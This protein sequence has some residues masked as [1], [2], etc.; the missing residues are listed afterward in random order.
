MLKT[1]KHLLT[2]KTWYFL[3]FAILLLPF[4]A[5]R[6]SPEVSR[7]RKIA[8][9]LK[10]D[11]QGER[12]FANRIQSACRNLGWKADL[13]EI[14]KFRRLKKHSY[15][16]VINLV[17][18]PCNFRNTKYY[19]AIFHPLHHYFDPDGSLSKPYRNYDGYL[20]TYSPKVDDRNFGAGGMP[21]IK[22]YPT[23]QTREYK[24][25]DPTALFYLG[26]IWGN[27][28]DDAKMQQFL[29]LLDK[30]SFT[31]IYGNPLLK[32]HC[33]HNYHSS[34][35][36]DSDSVCE[37]ANQAGV[38]LVLHSN[39]H[40][41]Y[42]LPSGRIFEAAAA[43]TTIICDENPFVRE[44]FGDSVLYINTDGS[45]ES[46]HNQIK[47]H[48]D[49]IQ[50]DKKAAREKARSAHTIYKYS[51]SLEE[52]LLRL[53]AFHDERSKTAFL[54]WRTKMIS[55]FSSWVKKLF[56]LS[57]LAAI[58]PII[59]PAPLSVIPNIDSHYSLINSVDFH[60]Q[61]NIACAVYT[62]NNKIVLYEIDGVHPPRPIQ[63]LCNPIILQRNRYISPK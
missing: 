13:F 58:L 9:L 23:V 46:I 5:F 19:L 21:Y 50:S 34:I 40:N 39:E 31:R 52:Q 57:G 4:L 27:R 43:S 44:H 30:E 24:E 51:F 20:L 55:L 3:F 18:G 16:F 8:V 36:F 1:L 54:E 45:A 63:P 56:S 38:T 42:G 53:G 25:T 7:T 12:A 60:P 62:H 10:M 35:Q 32:K 48:M 49:W 14:K 22:W 47:Q 15:D 26:C 2:S 37:T 61:S 17:P 29:N 41:A 6:T 11:Y 33:S 59:D 28:F